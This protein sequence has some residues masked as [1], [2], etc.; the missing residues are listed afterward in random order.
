MRAAFVGAI[1]AL[2]LAPAADAAKSKKKLGDFRMVSLKV[3]KKTVTAGSTVVASG[4]VQ[5]RKGRRAQTARVTYTLRKSRKAKS[6]RRLGADSIKRT[7]GGKFR[8][9]SERLRVASTVKPGTYYLTACVR[10]GSGTLKAECARKQ[11][12]VKAKPAKP[13]T[14]PPPDKRTLG[15]KLRDAVNA[16]GMYNHLRA[17]QS[18]ADANGGNRASGTSGFDASAQYVV[19]QLEA[20]GYDAVTQEFTFP[21]WD[22][23]KTGHVFEKTDAPTKT[24]ALETDYNV[25][26]YS[27]AGDTGSQDVL[28][29]DPNFAGDRASTDGCEDADFP[30]AKVYT[31]KIALIQRGTCTFYE[32]AIN[33]QE[34]GAVGV[35]FFNQGNTADR[36]GPISGVTMGGDGQ[37]G[38]PSDGE[39]LIPVV[40]TSFAIGQEL[41]GD[42][43]M[44]RVVADVTNTLKTTRN[45]VAETAGGNADHVV[46]MGGHLDS[47]SEGPGINDNGTGSAFVLE[48]AIQLHKL[49]ITPANKMRFSFWGAEEAGLLGSQFYVDSLSEDALNKIR[50]YLN[51]DMIGSPN[52]IRLVYD[53]DFSDS[54]APAAAPDVNE[55]AAEIERAFNGY[56]ASRNQPTRPTAFD[57]RSDYEGFQNEGIPSGGLFTGADDVKTREEAQVFG[58]IP[59]QKLDPNY[60]QAGDTL[61]NVNRGIL[62]E[63]ADAAAVVGGNYADDPSIRGRF[64]R[65]DPDPSGRIRPRSAV[66][67]S[68][69]EERGHAAVR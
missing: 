25:L 43:D 18:I 30:A 62:E 48:T 33:A 14:P 47:V 26:E 1:L 68:S 35:I 40:G 36:E 61:E 37:D 32:K 52:W 22:E 23:D 57:G 13:A 21:V 54:D 12:K 15:E 6:G 2:V 27:E 42:D 34:R 65:R 64:A 45:V 55:G 3:S 4:R 16:D 7:R 53:G 8:K 24:Y 60:H 59:A 17:L 58:G 41:A 11:L 39:L 46:Q 56:F 69:V 31:G 20:N 9:Y 38:D 50:M 28:Q 63:M 29:V 66:K 44:A 5:N 49:G 19:D 67:R 10:R 51:Y